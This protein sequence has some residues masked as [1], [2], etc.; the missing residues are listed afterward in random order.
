M[1]CRLVQFTF[2]HLLLRIVFSLLYNIAKTSNIYL[3]KNICPYPLKIIL[4]PSLAI[5]LLLIRLCLFC[6]SV[7]IHVRCCRLLTRGAA[8]RHRCLLFGGIPHAESVHVAA[9]YCVSEHARRPVNLKSDGDGGGGRKK[10]V[11]GGKTK[12]KL[13]YSPRTVNLERDGR[14]GSQMNEAEGWKN[15]K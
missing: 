4:Y 6:V 8:R 5:K 15:E 12:N 13:L 7:C 2:C 11:R 3:C 10:G 14:G 9:Y 1:F